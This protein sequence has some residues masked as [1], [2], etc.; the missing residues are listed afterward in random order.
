MK[1]IVL[2]M[3]LPFLLYWQKT[4]ET[5]GK[6]SNKGDMQF[7]ESVSKN[8]KVVIDDLTESQRLPTNKFLITTRYELSKEKVAEY[9][10]NN[11]TLENDDNDISDSA[12]YVIKDYSLENENGEKLK[13]VDGGNYKVLQETSLGEY[14]NKLQQ[15]L[16]IKLTLDK[17]FKTLKGSV[18]IELQLPGNQNKD[19]KIP[20]NISIEDKVSD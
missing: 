9:K 7:L 5:V 13:I 14:H 4:A 20:V 17:K 6:S 1:K 19:V 18:N 2:I 8:M 3:L 16:I 15:N 11:G 12:K 10:K